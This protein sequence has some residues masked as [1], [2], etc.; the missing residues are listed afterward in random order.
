MYLGECGFN[1][2]NCTLIETTL[3]NLSD[4]HNAGSLTDINV[5][6]PHKL[7]F[8]ASFKSVQVVTSSSP[9]SLPL[10]TPS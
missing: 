1:G 4:G 7:N 9:S 2:E 5:R 6:P 10:S 3:E 8:V